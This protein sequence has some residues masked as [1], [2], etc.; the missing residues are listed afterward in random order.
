MF[1]ANFFVTMHAMSIAMMGGKSPAMRKKEV[2]KPG[3][4]DAFSFGPCRSDMVEAMEE[5]RDDV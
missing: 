2:R 1:P 3:W 5:E 4:N